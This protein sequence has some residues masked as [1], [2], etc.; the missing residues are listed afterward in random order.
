M[1][2]ESLNFN[3]EKCFL[4]PEIFFLG[5]Y[6]HYFIPKFNLPTENRDFFLVKA[7]S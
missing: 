7:R 3:L 5:F 4:R 6:A 2:E 1:D